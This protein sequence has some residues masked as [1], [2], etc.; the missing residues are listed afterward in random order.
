MH[1]PFPDF[2]RVSIGPSSPL[3]VPEGTTARLECQVDVEVVVG[4]RRTDRT[5]VGDHDTVDRPLGVVAVRAR[6]RTPPGASSAPRTTGWDRLA[7][8]R[9]SSRYLKKSAHVTLCLLLSLNM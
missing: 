5:H 1:R 2:P 9:S 7:R 4:R 6:R 3:R 8:Q